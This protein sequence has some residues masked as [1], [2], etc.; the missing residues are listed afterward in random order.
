MSLYSHITGTHTMWA[1]FTLFLSLLQSR[2]RMSERCEEAAR[3][4]PTAT[5]GIQ[6]EERPK[7][8]EAQQ[9]GAI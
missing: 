8:Q 3:S 7:P 2:S 1:S 4:I 9:A 5:M 6:G